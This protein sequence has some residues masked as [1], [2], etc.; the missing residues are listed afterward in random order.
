MK[1]DKHEHLVW[2]E[3]SRERVLKT[4]IFTVCTIH[5]KSSAGKNAAFTFL[6]CGE[7]A[8]IVPLLKNEAGED[9]FLM[10]RQFRQG[11]QSLTLE[12]PGGL[13]DPGET[14]QEAA[15]RELREETGYEA[16][17]ISFA[18]EINPN[19]AFMGNRCSTF[20]AEGLRKTSAQDLDENELVDCELVPV[21]E[22]EKNMGK[23]VY[24]HAIMVVAFFWY[25]QWK[26]EHG[27]P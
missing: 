14:A 7:W 16:G 15:A 9:C 26:A 3:V 2:T 19:P 4:P 1:N 6:E 12:F 17:R 8:N 13:V 23:G 24:N 25:Q 5:R 20:I 21:S 27:G 18:G 22:L 10:V 11:G